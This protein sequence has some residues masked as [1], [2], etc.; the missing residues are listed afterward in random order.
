[1]F[2]AVLCM[3]IFSTIRLE[4]IFSNGIEYSTIRICPSRDALMSQIFLKHCDYK[5]DI[6]RSDRCLV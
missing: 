3:S 6:Q 5:L 4:G 1:M 2:Y